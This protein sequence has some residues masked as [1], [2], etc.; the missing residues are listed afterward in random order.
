MP[1]RIFLLLM[2]LMAIWTPLHAQD[3]P[4]DDDNAPP[5][6]LS[7]QMGKVYY[8]GDSIPS[9][10]TPTLYKY[11]PME[12]K[13]QRQQNRYN[14]LVKNVKQTLPMAKL[15][16]TTMIETYEYLETLPTKEARERHIKAVEKGLWQQYR[17][18]MKK[19]S[20][21][22]GKLLIKLID[23]ECNQ[24]SFEMVKAFMGSFKANSYQ[25][26]AWLFGASLKKGYDPDDDDRFTERIVRMVESGQL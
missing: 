6:P 15:V 9:F 22:Q 5:V 21:S 19:L 2:C 17:P 1:V 4:D 3:T 18:T 10:T 8:K 24:S 7:V 23:R 26:F 11:P 12:F 25:A 20:Y 14:R 16:K 13:N